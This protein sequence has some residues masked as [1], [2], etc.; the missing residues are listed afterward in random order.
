MPLRILSLSI[1]L[2]LTTACRT[3]GPDEDV[4]TPLPLTAPQGATDP[5]LKKVIGDLTQK[6]P[7][8]REE[9]CLI[10]R[11]DVSNLQ[12]VDQA[13]TALSH[14]ELAE[15]FIF[16]AQIPSIQ[17]FAFLKG[18]AILVS[19]LSDEKMKYRKPEGELGNPS[20]DIL[21]NVFENKC[22]ASDATP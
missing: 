19:E 8:N 16:R 12:D 2:L 20:L 22:G 6:Y 4:T 11:G 7:E 17:Y 21:M 3:S 1:A 15:A 14:Q 5:V 13:I 9:S 18:E 10:L